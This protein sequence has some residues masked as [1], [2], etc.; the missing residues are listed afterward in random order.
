VCMR[1]PV[2]YEQT[3]RG[4][5][6]GECVRHTLKPHSFTVRFGVTGGW[7]CVL[8]RDVFLMCCLA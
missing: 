8:G 5:A 1:T 6:C 2:H 7:L 3:V 4:G